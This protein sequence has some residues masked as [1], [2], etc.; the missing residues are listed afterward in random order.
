[1]CYALDLVMCYATNLQMCIK[2]EI[3]GPELVSVHNYHNSAYNQVF[4]L[5]KLVMPR[6]Y[7]LV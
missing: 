4:F 3:N 7:I 2:N 1:M 5:S 6:F